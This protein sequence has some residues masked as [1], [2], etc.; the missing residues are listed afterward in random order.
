MFR[1]QG[2]DDACPGQ[3]G[4]CDWDNPD[5]DVDLAPR[6]VTDAC[7]HNNVWVRI[8]TGS[9]CCA[10]YWRL[11]IIDQGNP[12]GY[13]ELGEW[14]LGTLRTFTK[15]RL[16]PGRADGPRF[17]EGT[18]ET[19]YGQI[20][21][22]FYAHAEEEFSILIKNINSVDQVSEMRCFVTAVKQAGGKFVFIPNIRQKFCYYVYMTNM[23]EFA[24]QVAKGP[25]TELYDWTIQLRTLVKGITL[26]GGSE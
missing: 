23:G 11:A 12:D 7:V 8:P 14:F 16:Q 22:A 1:L 10:R 15:A 18:Q 9:G 6:M 25:T 17:Y 2:C 5:C 19:F 20:W 21:S 13:L 26:L 24:Q 3:S 4:A